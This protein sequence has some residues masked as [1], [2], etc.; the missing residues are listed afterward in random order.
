MVICIRGTVASCSGPILV[1]V[2]VFG[3]L[4]IV[5]PCTTCRRTVQVV[6][7]GKV[8]ELLSLGS[9]GVLE[10]Q[11]LKLVY[12]VEQVDS[13]AAVGVRWL[14]K[15]HIVPVVKRRAHGHCSR[16]ALLL[17]H[18]V[19]LHDVGVHQTENFLLS[20]LVFSIQV[21]VLELLNHVEVV[22]EFVEPVLAKWRSQVYHEGDRYRIEHVLVQVL[23]KFGHRFD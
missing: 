3:R 18:L 19:M 16:L 7:L 23:G 22:G 11:S 12:C 8:L 13:T 15:P 4:S 9:G 5:D 10:D 20:V 17:T 14:E 1:M 21:L 2:V 6:R